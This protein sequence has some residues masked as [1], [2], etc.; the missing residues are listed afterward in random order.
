MS[1]R[2]ASDL[3]D[4]DIQ[5]PQ[6]QVRKRKLEVEIEWVDSKLPEG[7]ERH[8]KKTARRVEGK[9]H[10]WRVPIF[11]GDGEIA[12]QCLQIKHEDVV[13]QWQ[14]RSFRDA[15]ETAELTTAP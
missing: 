6:G 13:Q 2:C 3:G 14:L 1:V 12:K 7:F 4:E 5:L 10:K 15:N 11:V 8:L 9:Y